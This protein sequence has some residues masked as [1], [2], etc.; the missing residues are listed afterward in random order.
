MLKFSLHSSILF[1]NSISILITKALN[2][3]SRKLFA[4]VQLVV[5]L[6]DFFLVLS[7][8]TNSSVFSDFLELSLSL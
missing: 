7:F 8:E 2:S 3:L 1:P 6:R 4:S 5:F